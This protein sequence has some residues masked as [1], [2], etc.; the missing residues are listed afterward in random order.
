MVERQE[1]LWQ[2]GLSIAEM[3]AKH[4]AIESPTTADELK[5]RLMRIAMKPNPR[6]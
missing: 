4:K 1:D 2:E 5:R 6:L 3:F